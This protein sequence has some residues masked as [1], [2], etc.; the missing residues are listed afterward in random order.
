MASFSFL[1]FRSP[2]LDS[3]VF[4]ALYRANSIAGMGWGRVRGRK[5]G[6]QIAR[7]IGENR[8]TAF[9]NDRAAEPETPDKNKEA[10]NEQ[11]A[12]VGGHAKGRVHSECGWHAEELGSERAFLCGLGNLSPEGVDSGPEPVVCLAVEQLV[13]TGGAALGRWREDVE[14][15][16]EQVCVRG[17]AGDAPMV[18]RDSASVGVQ[19]GVAP[20][21]EEHTSELQSPMY[22]VCRL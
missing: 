7:E 13:R 3:R 14:C 8:R 21:S 15:G 5:N 17:R 9:P 22:L 4:S 12:S 1:R 11:G 16:G 20:R 18:R 19:A 10:S 2:V 6:L